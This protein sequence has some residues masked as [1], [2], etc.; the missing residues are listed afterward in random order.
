M[1]ELRNILL[2]QLYLTEEHF[3]S[4][5]GRIEFRHL[6]KM[7]FLIRQGSVC[8]FIAFI[9][10]GNMRSFITAKKGQVNNDFY[11][12]GNFATAYTSFLV[13]SP[14]NCNIEALTEVELGLI[15]RQTLNNLIDEDPI[16]LKL[17]AFISNT[18]FIRKCK[19]ETSFLKEDAAGRLQQL[20]AQ[21]P[22]IEQMIPQHHIASYLGIQPESLSR[23]KS[24]QTATKPT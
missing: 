4:L 17:S 15:T 12:P 3:Q 24:H 6:S 16:W 1:E 9:F 21:Y 14:T 13:Q 8:T 23:L 20:L 10:S 22:G 2:G 18:Y 7:D 5:W 19:R 11:F